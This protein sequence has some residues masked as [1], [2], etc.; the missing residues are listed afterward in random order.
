MDYEERTVDEVRY[1][2]ESPTDEWRPVRTYKEAVQSLLELTPEQRGLVFNLFC[3]SC[4]VDDPRCQ[5]WNDE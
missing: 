5:C 2:R 4:G 1:F 3:T